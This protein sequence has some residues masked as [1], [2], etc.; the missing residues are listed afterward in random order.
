[1]PGKLGDNNAT[2]VDGTTLTWDMSSSATPYHFTAQSA[3]GGS[4][5]T[6][7]IFVAVLLCGCCLVIVVIGGGIAAYFILRK[8]KPAPAA[9]DLSAPLTPHP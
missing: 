7:W 1:M 6:V 9:P 5:S 4:D 8:R 2:K 3:T